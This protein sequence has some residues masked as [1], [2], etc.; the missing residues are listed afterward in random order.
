[1]SLTNDLETIKT[2]LFKTIHRRRRN[3]R[4]GIVGGALAVAVTCTAAAFII[5]ATP[6]E[7]S[8]SVICYEEAD[9]SARTTTVVVPETITTQD[10]SAVD[11][12]EALNPRNVC[13]D[14]WRMGVLGQPQP[15][16]IDPN[17]ANFPV[18]P[19]AGCKQNNGVGVG[20]PIE[21]DSTEKQLCARVGLTIWG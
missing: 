13:A 6:E 14:I 3:A 16:E 11:R 2:R 4:L 10:G 17:V 21:D 15:L 12:G 19:I 5:E 18:P 1:M 8:Y 9:L 7:I 20:L